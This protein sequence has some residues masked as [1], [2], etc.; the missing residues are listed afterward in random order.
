MSNCLNVYRPRKA[1]HPLHVR[2]TI[3]VGKLYQDPKTLVEMIP[4]DQPFRKKGAGVT[5][6][7]GV[8][9]CQ[10]QPAGKIIA[11]SKE[12]IA[13]MDLNTY[14][15]QDYTKNRWYVKGENAF[16]PNEFTQLFNT[17]APL[18]GQGNI[19]QCN[20]TIEYRQLPESKGLR[21]KHPPGIYCYIRTSRVICPLQ[22][23]ILDNYGKGSQCLRW[24]QEPT[25]KRQAEN[26]ARFELIESTKSKQVG[27]VTCRLCAFAI[28]RG[29]INKHNLICSKNR[30]TV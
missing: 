10:K 21:K 1:K 3:K 27:N 4:M 11:I 7:I 26:M 12:P 25:L 30:V 17:R 24:G 8:K 13:K 18:D 29:G 28:P 20:A 19:E 22:F 9:V 6:G 16:P 5:R 23:V 2:K 15:K 14:T